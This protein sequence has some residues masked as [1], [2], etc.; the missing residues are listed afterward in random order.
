MGFKQKLAYI[1]L[2][3]VILLSGIAP[4]TNAK[5]PEETRIV[6]ESRRRLIGLS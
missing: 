6:F 3:C 4:F 2:S 1:S 5:A